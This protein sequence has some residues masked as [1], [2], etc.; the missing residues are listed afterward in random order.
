MS[1]PAP[2]TIRRS[3]RPLKVAAKT[4]FALLVLAVAWKLAAGMDWETLRSRLGQ[5]DRALAA[6][7]ALL[8]AGRLVAWAQRWGLALARLGEPSRPLRRLAAVAASV[9]VNHATPY[10]RVFGAIFRARYLARG[11]RLS[12]GRHYGV[13]L[14]DQATHGAAAALLLWGVGVV[15]AWQR[16]SLLLVAVGLGVGAAASLSVVGLRSG[17]ISLSSRLVETVIAGARARAERFPALAEH[18][19]GLVEMLRRLLG[20]GDLL[21]AMIGWSLVYATFNAGAQWLVFR[22]L[23]VEI[24]LAAVVAVVGGGVIVGAVTGSPGGVATT[25]AAMAAGFIAL[26][27]GETDAAAAT[28]IYR[29]LHYAVVIATGVPALLYFELAERRGVRESPSPAPGAAS[30]S[31]PPPSGSAVDPDE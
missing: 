2:S 16:G 18:G 4:I 3:H 15:L 27:I 10:L 14:F 11:S 23:D 19:R 28:L 30:E 21:L 6:A 17:R 1:R 8:L 13:V 9:A 24:G 7:A 5:V 12:F 26:G 20:Q 25:E 22:A 29:G 31:G